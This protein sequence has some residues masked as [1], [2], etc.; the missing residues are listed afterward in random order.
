MGTAFE[1]VLAALK[2]SPETSN[3]QAVPGFPDVI[4]LGIDDQDYELV[5][6]AF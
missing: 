5:M 2:A 6:A 4:L 1:H 3:A